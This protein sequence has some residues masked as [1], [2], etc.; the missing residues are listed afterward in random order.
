MPGNISEA[1][2]TQATGAL[3]LV[4]QQEV[5]LLRQHVVVEMMKGKDSTVVNQIGEAPARVLTGRHQATV[6]GNI[7]HDVRHAHPDIYQGTVLLSTT[8]LL[9]TMIKPTSAYIRAIAGGI[10]VK[11]DQE[12]IRA[13]LQPAMTGQLGTTAVALP[14]SQ[15][16]VHGGT[17]LTIEKLRQAMLRFRRAKV[18]TDNTKLYIYVDPEQLNDL[19]G[20][21]ETTSADFNNVQA[22]IAGTLKYFMGF[23]F[24]ITT[25]LPKTS[26]VRSCVAYAEGGLVLGDWEDIQL[27]AD[28]LPERNNDIGVIGRQT[29]GATRTQEKKVVQIDCQETAA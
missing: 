28:R 2:Y 15:K 7:D 26:R 29:L 20:T 5:S 19:L 23:H 4:L 27:T 14:A 16:I 9:M 6:W 25:E 10:G 24:V 11:T 3:E 1:F 8:D 18:N 21:V 13:A 12:I 22:L 17:G